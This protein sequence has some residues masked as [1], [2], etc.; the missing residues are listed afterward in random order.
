MGINPILEDQKFLSVV[1]ISHKKINIAKIR[2]NSNELHSETGHWCIPKNPWV[3]RVFHLCESMSLEDEHQFLLEY[4]TYTHISYEFH[5]IYYNT[6][7][8]KPIMS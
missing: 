3:E 4:P 2:I 5:S 1:T 6:N 7:L 8:S